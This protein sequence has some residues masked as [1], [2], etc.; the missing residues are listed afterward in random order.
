MAK[1][2]GVSARIGRRGITGLGQIGEAGGVTDLKVVERSHLY[3]SGKSLMLRLIHPL[4]VPGREYSYLGFGYLYRSRQVFPS[5]PRFYSWVG[6]PWL[7]NYFTLVW[8][9]RN[10]MDV[11][12]D[13]I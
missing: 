10:G 7:S 5:V 8:G 3:R 1:Q 9:P 6:L 11:R 4:P 12:L 13:L 2:P